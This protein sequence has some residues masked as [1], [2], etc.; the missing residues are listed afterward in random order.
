MSESDG[1]LPFA[2]AGFP[3]ARVRRPLEPFF[4]ADVVV[5]FFV[6]AAVLG[7]SKSSEPQIIANKSLVQTNYY[8]GAKFFIKRPQGRVTICLQYKADIETC[9]QRQR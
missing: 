1:V 5:F 8:S 4:E 3:A 2:F 9:W 7:K 6:A